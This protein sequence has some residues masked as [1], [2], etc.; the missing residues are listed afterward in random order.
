L[1]PHRNQKFKHRDPQSNPAEDM[2]PSCGRTF[3]AQSRPTK[4]DPLPGA[5]GTT[6]IGLLGNLRSAS[7]GAPASGTTTVAKT[8]QQNH[9]VSLK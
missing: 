8:P 3:S 6:R 5:N 9:A 1:Q 4:S 2:V 7:A